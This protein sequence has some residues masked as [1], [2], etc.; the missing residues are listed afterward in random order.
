[1]LC[2][3]PLSPTYNLLFLFSVYPKDFDSVCVCFVPSI[4]MVWQ[5][6]GSHTGGFA[7]DEGTKLRTPLFKMHYPMY[8]HSPVVF[9]IRP[10]AVQLL[11]AQWLHPQFADS[12]PTD[13]AGHYFE[14]IWQLLKVKQLMQ[15]ILITE[16]PFRHV[17]CDCTAETRLVGQ[18][19]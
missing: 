5:R 6:S 19:R 17:H 12:S 14:W 1:M 15:P 10:P 9:I 16:Q 18:Q 7:S 11:S 2:H 4:S 13:K 3:P 8:I